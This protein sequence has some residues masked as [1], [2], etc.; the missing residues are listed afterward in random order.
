MRIANERQQS[1]MHAE[2]NGRRCRSSFNARVNTTPTSNTAINEAMM[3][4]KKRQ[5][6][7]LALYGNVSE[8]T[9]TECNKTA[10]TV[11]YWHRFAYFNRK[12]FVSCFQMLLNLPYATG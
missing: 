4:Q 12:Y 8:L 2:I 10:E 11:D 1:A 6:Q 7:H 5:K 3:T 9:L